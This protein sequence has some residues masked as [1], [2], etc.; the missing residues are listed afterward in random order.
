[1]IA[2]L[3]LLALA[4]AAAHQVIDDSAALA[5][6][7]GSPDL[8]AQG[9]LYSAGRGPGADASASVDLLDQI[10]AALLADVGVRRRRQVTAGARSMLEAIDDMAEDLD[11]VALAYIER[12]MIGV[13]R[14]LSRLLDQF[15]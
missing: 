1:M 2:P 5:P 11:D 6:A 14:Q 13:E 8:T 10:N 4:T 12:R 15:E 7:P 3:L 9:L